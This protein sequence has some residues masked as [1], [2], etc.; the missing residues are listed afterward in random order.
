MIIS[1]IKMLESPNFDHMTTFTISFD[2]RNIILLVTSWVKIMT[3]QPLFNLNYFC[4]AKKWEHGSSAI[5]KFIYIS[6]QI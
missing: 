1:V 4:S 3:S 5:F 2:E 6:V